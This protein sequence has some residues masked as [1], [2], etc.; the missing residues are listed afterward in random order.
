MALFEAQQD[1]PQIVVFID[2]KTQS[3]TSTDTTEARE[4]ILSVIPEGAPEATQESVL[5]VIARWF[6]LK[7]K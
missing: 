7:I 6:E 4:R 5:V 2:S 1:H 3:K